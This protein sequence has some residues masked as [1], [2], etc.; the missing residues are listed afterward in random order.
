MHWIV[1][2][3]GVVVALVLAAGS[4]HL[5]LTWANRRGW[6]WYRNEGRPSPRSLGLLE[7][8]YQPSVE[9][10][11]EYETGEVLIDESLKSLADEFGARFVRIH[12]GALVAVDRI[13]RVEKTP[14]GKSRVILRGRSHVDDN[15]MIISRRHVAEVR[16][17]LK[18]S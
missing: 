15:E 12:R 1:V 14:E 16:R 18:E 7:E 11:V 8:I 6:V 3:V 17:R 10:V 13:E 2:A 9:H 4:V 5:L